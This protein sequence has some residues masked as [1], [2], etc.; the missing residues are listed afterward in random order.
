VS[1]FIAFDTI[2]SKRANAVIALRMARWCGVSRWIE[3]VM[4][5]YC[6]ERAIPRKE[7]RM[8]DAGVALVRIGTSLA[9][10]GAFLALRSV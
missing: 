5:I 4:R 7:C 8:I 10:E 2:S 3:V 1:V 6:A 9:S